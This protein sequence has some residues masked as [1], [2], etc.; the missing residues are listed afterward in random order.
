MNIFRKLYLKFNSF[1]FSLFVGF[2][3]VDNILVSNQTETDEINKNILKENGG[4]YKDILEQK[5]TQEVEE[6]R[7]A[8]Y[9]VVSESKKYKYIGNGKATLKT[10]NQLNEKHCKVDES[11]NLPIILIQDNDLICADTYSI[12]CEVNERKNKKVN[13]DYTLK[14]KR[15]IYP[16]F[17]IEKYVKKIVVKQTETNL[18][19]DLYCSI[20]P[21]QYSERQDKS[22]LSEL[23]KLKNGDIKNSDILEFS[24]IS[25]ITSHAFGSED[26]R[27]FTFIDFEYYDIIEYDGNYIIRM[28]CIPKVFDENILDKIYS[29]TK[30]EKYKRKEMKNDT[31]YIWDSKSEKNTSDKIELDNFENVLF[32]L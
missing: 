2:K 7:Y 31:Y 28:G 13:S 22:F 23:R 10:S 32:S 17:F 21:K 18:V 27:K 25:F 11:D 8:S 24:E 9:K 15:D 19:I 29:E 14:F 1:I 20:Y 4:V 12:L 30:E 5:V 3:N 6:L 16:R 26:W